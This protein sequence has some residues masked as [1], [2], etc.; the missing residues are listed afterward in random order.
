MNVNVQIDSKKLEGHLKKAITE[1]PRVV[2]MAMDRTAGTASND[3]IKRTQKGQGVDGP[4][5]AYARKYAEAK[6]KGWGGTKSRRGFGGDSSG[7]VNLTLHGDMT[8]DV[9][10][11]PAKIISGK[12]EAY[13]APARASEKRKVFYTDRVRHW[14]GF[15]SKE[16]KYISRIFSGHFKQLF[17]GKV[18]FS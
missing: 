8:G 11:F 10:P 16:Q 9:V 3:L 14:W 12:I 17:R 13:I 2:A 1:T 6:R 5:R 18:G 15:S 4:L 7:V